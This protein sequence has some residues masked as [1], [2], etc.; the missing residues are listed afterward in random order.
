MSDEIILTI[1][2]QVRGT[3]EPRY[4]DGRGQSPT[5]LADFATSRPARSR[6]CATSRG[7]IPRRKG[8]A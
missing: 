2:G 8:T 4:P 6:R 3:H 5:A 7:S 1:D